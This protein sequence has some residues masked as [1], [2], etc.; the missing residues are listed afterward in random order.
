MCSFNHTFIVVFWFECPVDICDVF[1]LSISQS[2][3]A[4]PS[5]NIKHNVLNLSCLLLLFWDVLRYREDG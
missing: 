3:S 2:L 4:I 5:G 1:F